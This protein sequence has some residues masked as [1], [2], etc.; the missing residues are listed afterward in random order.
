MHDVIIVGG[1]YAGLA[2]ALQLARARRDVLIIDAG[3]RRNRFASHSHGFLGQDGVPPAAIAAKGKAEV[4]QYPSVQWLDARVTD[5]RAVDGGFVIHAQQAEH[6]AK[7]LILATGV[8]DELP[9][10]PG[11]A[12]RW[13]KGV[14]HCPYC[15]GY[16]RN[17]GKLGVLASGSHTVPYAMLVNEWSSETVLF[18]NGGE[19]PRGEDL[20]Q[21]ESRK[22]QIEK[23]EVIEVKDTTNGIGVTTR[24]RSYELAALFAGSRTRLAGDLATK[25]GCAIEP[26]SMG[27][28]YKTDPMTKETTVAGVYACGD[29]AIPQ[30][31]VTFAVADG[32]RAGISAHQSLVFGSS[33]R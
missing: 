19:V 30:T 7:R 14:F 16:E 24:D 3:E 5:A 28:V 18:L 17:R 32:A 33:H 20:A 13:G 2:A 31:T 27:A 22:I 26:T 10:I 6:R 8:V 12:E 9:R 4:L 15:D 1:S 21:L 29:V 11:L 25:L 23:S